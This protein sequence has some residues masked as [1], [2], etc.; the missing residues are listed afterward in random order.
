MNDY[1]MTNYKVLSNSTF[2]STVKKVLIFTVVLLPLIFSGCAKEDPD[3]IQETDTEKTSNFAKIFDGNSNTITG[4]VISVEHTDSPKGS[5]INKIVDGVDSTFFSTPRNSFY[6]LWNANRAMLVN[7]YSITSGND[8]LQDP[9]SWT[10]SGSNDNAAWTLLDTRTNEA[11]QANMEKKEYYFVNSTAYKYYK[12]EIAENNGAASTSMAE[13]SFLSKANPDLPFSSEVG[14]QNLNMPTAG[15]ISSQFSDAPFGSNVLSLIDSKSTTSFITF[16]SSFY[17]LWSGNE[18]ALINYYALTSAADKPEYDPKSWKLSA[19]NDSVNWTVL[20][21]RVNV[22]FANRE[23]RKEYNLQNTVSYKFYRLDV[24]EN[25]GGEATQIAEWAI[26]NLDANMDDL[27]PYSNGRT[28]STLTPMGKRFENRHVTTQ[29]DKTWLANAAN[30]PSLL[31]SAPSL[32]QLKEFPVTLYPYGTPKPADVNQHAIGDC[33]AV[34][35]FASFAYLYPDFIKDI[36]TDNGDKTYTVA[37]FDPQGNPVNVTV[38]SKFLADGNG[39]IGA[40]TGKSDR[41]TWATV[42]EKALMKWQKI[43]KVNEDIGGIGTEHVAPIFTGDGDSFAFSAN[44]LN[45]ADLRRAVEVS[46]NQGKITIGGFTKSD[47]PVSGN[48]KTVS[49][50]AFTLMYSLDNAALFSMRNPWGGEG[51]GVLNIPNNSVIPPLIDLRIVNP[52]KAAKYAKGLPGPYTPPYLSP[53]QQS[54]RVSQELLNS[55]R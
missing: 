16:H 53:S 12:I 10:L 23:E 28:L 54:I 9:K 8:R 4:G 50:H 19:S 13:L 49:A 48:H 41:A 22:T 18:A 2:L 1:K 26:R 24:L 44:R 5:G 7:Y 35:V 38:S 40:V 46:L 52:G 17:I 47:L 11:F 20:D 34:A 27:M 3:P 32:T 29:A 45:S 15:I 37:M 14:E 31:G 51:D 42:L 30:E 21:T 36:I 55:G 25:N 33:S 43:Y 6:I 39:K